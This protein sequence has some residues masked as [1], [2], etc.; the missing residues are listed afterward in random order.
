MLYQFQKYYCHLVLNGLQSTGL[1][2]YL[3]HCLS[4][5]GLLT[6]MTH[7]PQA[8]VYGKSNRIEYHITNVIHVADGNRIKVGNTHPLASPRSQFKIQIYVPTSIGSDQ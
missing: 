2:T 5:A 6:T 3:Q 1:H 8:Y 7:F 4:T